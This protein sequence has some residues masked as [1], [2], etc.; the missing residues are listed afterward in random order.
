MREYR[1]STHDDLPVQ[2]GTPALGGSQ[3]DLAAG[4]SVDRMDAASRHP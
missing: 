1:E 4:S 3:L 2:P